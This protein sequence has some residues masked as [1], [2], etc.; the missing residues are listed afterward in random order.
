MV[1][2]DDHDR[3]VSPGFGQTLEEVAEKIAVY[4]R[5]R[6]AAGHD[7]ATGRVTLMLHTFVG[8][9]DAEVRE[10]VREPMKEYLRASLKLTG[11]EGAA[12]SRLDQAFERY[13]ETSGLFGTP[14]TGA[15]M[16]E[17]CRR[18]GVDEIACLLDFGVP[19]EQV[20]ASLPDLN[21]VRE[22]TSRQRV[23]IARNIERHGVTHV[24]CTPSLARMLL[25]DA[26]A[27]AALAGIRHLL[28]G[29]EALPAALARE[30]KSAIGGELTNM[31]GPTETTVWSAMHP[32]EPA[33]DPVPIG[34]PI[35]NT[36]ISIVDGFGQPL[37][38]GVPG[39]LVIG[40]AG[41]ARGYLN[42]PELTAERFINGS[43]RTGDVARF[44]ADGRI[45][46]LGRAD[47]Q[48]KIRGYRVELG[49]IES[50]LSGQVGQAAVSVHDSNLVAYVVGEADFAKLRAYLRAKL[51]DYMVP[52]EFVRLDRM[53]YTPNGKL[54]RKALPA[55]ERSAA[56]AEFVAPATL[57]E[58]ALAELWQ[59]VLRIERIGAKDN[60]FE[61]G[62]HSL[63]AMQLVVGVRERLGVELP[64]RN[65]FEHPVLAD[66]AEAID[67]LAWLERSKAPPARAEREETLL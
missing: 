36:Q 31:Y 6:A 25:A 41:V 22:M 34:R 23:S 12:E 20:L 8:A 1:P 47:G 54:D 37:P 33:D 55:P 67:A 10:L 57:T 43:Y 5:A 48:V 50:V 2:L 44:M 42:R 38:A 62:G 21:Q 65:L 18:A 66:L 14:A 46:Y 40:G 26:P 35:A 64:L 13:F 16:A 30:L 24:Q 58:R 53:P 59:R 32:V 15:R 3:R 56:A 9:D 49:E 61:S 39:E 4:R 19:T 51:P 60:F 17:R 7:P 29:G 11:L 63:L 52:S 45:E 28:V 27:R